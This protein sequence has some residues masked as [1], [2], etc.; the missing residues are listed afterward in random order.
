VNVNASTG[1]VTFTYYGASQR[2]THWRS[3]SYWYASFWLLPPL[4]ACSLPH[5][6]GE[7]AGRTAGI[8]M[9][10]WR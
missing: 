2:W 3:S 8:T 6:P 7:H 4:L 10:R 5:V 9:I 1:D